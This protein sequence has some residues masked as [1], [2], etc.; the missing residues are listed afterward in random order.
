[1]GKTL[2]IAEKPSVARDIAGVLGVKGGGDGA[3]EN[4]EYVISWAIGHLVVDCGPEEQNPAWGGAWTLDNLPMVPDAMKQ[5]PNEK[6]APQF[7]VLQK[8]LTSKDVDKVICATDAA[9]EGV[10][11]FQRIYKEAGA[12]KPYK[13]LW[14]SDMTTEGLKKAFANLL[15]ASAKEGVSDAGFGRN[16]ADWLVGF[17]FT[18]LYTVKCND[19]VSIGRVQT[20]V[21]KLLVDRTL[22]IANFKPSDFW[23]ISAHFMAGGEDFS[24]TWFGEPYKQGDEKLLDESRAKAIAAMCQGKPGAVDFVESKPSQ[25]KPPLPFDLTALQRE[26]N[27]K[28]GFSAQYTLTLA[29]ALYEIHK[30]LTYPRTDSRYLSDELLGEID[31]HLKAAAVNYADLAALASARVGSEKTFACVNSKKVSDH[32][33]IIPTG[34]AADQSKLSEDEWKVYDLVTRRFLAAFLPPAQVEATTLW[35]VIE[36]ERFK[37]T[38]Q[39]FQDKGWMVA[40]PWRSSEDT[41]LPKVTKGDALDAKAVKVEKK[42]TKAPAQHTE[43]S[44]LQAMQTAGK[45]VE[46][47]ELAETLKDRGLGTPATRAGII[48]TI[49][50][51]GFAERLKKSLVATDKGIK[52]IQ[53]VDALHPEMASPELTGEWERRLRLIEDG[54]ETLDA[55]RADIRRFVSEGV[56]KGKTGEVL[57]KGEGKRGSRVEVG[58]CPICGKPVCENLKAFGCTGYPDCKFAVWKTVCGGKVSAAAAKQILTS[59]RTSKELTFKSQKTGKPFKARLQLEGTEVKFLFA[60]K[61][62]A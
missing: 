55:F 31:K 32:H 13:Y 59:K 29:Q 46:D 19:L 20:P 5:K 52:V 53:T 15:P 16:E 49:L 42:Q 7:R 33:A 8:F 4:G 9:R 17:N 43:A 3:I 12:S 1:M 27:T 45:I 2:I 48:E 34:T 39:A 50:A 21:L 38:G 18:R 11:I 44:L 23:T 54:Q 35:I 30:G 47:E 26:A 6:T 37:A 58:P 57:Y 10:H 56:A 24:T 22:E 60:P 62:K 41:I 25:K 36:G 51:R 40:E 14:A 61:R 28:F